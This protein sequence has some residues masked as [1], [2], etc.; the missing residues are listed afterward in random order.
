[1]G[2]LNEKFPFTLLPQMIALGNDEYL[3]SL[4]LIW[5]FAY[6][7][8]AI[9]TATL[10]KHVLEAPPGLPRME[11]LSNLTAY[12]NQVWKHFFALE[13][14]VFRNN[15]TSL[16]FNYMML[17]YGYS[18]SLNFKIKESASSTTSQLQESSQ[19]LQQQQTTAATII[20]VDPNKGNLM[21]AV[22]E[23]KTFTYTQ[24]QRRFECKFKQQSGLIK[25]QVKSSQVLK[26]NNT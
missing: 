5:H 9:H 19:Y 8:L 3:Q 11:M 2:V 10:I 16:M 21:Y 7:C 18:C 4:T 22:S 14:R 20:G 17:T 25:K 15:S 1:M 24:K 6:Q 12:K 13:E 26:L 23:G